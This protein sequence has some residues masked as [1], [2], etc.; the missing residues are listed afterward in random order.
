MRTIKFRA[1]SDAKKE[2]YYDLLW[3][4]SDKGTMMFNDIIKEAQK[5][6]ELMQFVEI[7]D[8]NGEDV[9]EGDIVE[10]KTGV[11]SVV[12][13]ENGMFVGKC[14]DGMNAYK[15]RECKKIGNIYENP[16]LLR[17]QL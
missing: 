17:I 12:T 1:W 14:K 8:Q 9:Y 4:D 3:L 6:L 7:I 10:D 15:W 5:N 13:Y 2:M 11:V 16:E